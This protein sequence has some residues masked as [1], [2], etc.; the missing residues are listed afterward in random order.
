MKL[1]VKIDPSKKQSLLNLF[2]AIKKDNDVT[3]IVGQRTVDLLKAA[4]KLNRNEYDAGKPLN[5]YYLDYR[6]KLATKNK[7]A[8]TYRKPKPNVFTGEFIESMSFKK[9]ADHSVDIIFKDNHSQYT[10]LKGKKI[11]SIISNEKLA[12]YLNE[13]RKFLFLSE[14]IK[15]KIQKNL[16]AVIRQKLSVYKKFL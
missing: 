2:D 5:K 9:V 13:I 11:G 8:I 6:S 10:G 12:G 15:D 7:T 3:N 1:K 16:V 14:S 4:V